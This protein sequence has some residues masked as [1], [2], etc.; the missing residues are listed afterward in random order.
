MR[1][2]LLSLTFLVILA[3]ISE[4]KP[5]ISNLTVDPTSL[6]LGESATISLNCIDDNENNTIIKTYL[7]ISGP[8]IFI[9][10]WDME[11]IQGNKYSLTIDNSYL[12]KT[13]DYEVNVY[14]EN[15]AGDTE[16]DKVTFRISNLINEINEISPDPAYL[17]DQLEIDVFVKKDDIKLNSGVNFTVEIGDYK[18]TFSQDPPP[19]YDG[20]R[21]WILKI[22]IPDSIGVYDLVVQSKYDRAQATVQDQIEIKQP[23]QFD[24]VN[25][26]KKYLKDSENITLTFQNS[27]KGELFDLSKNNLK[28]WID[29]TDC[30]IL[31]TSRTGSYSYV[32]IKVPN[33]SPG[34]YDL[35][36]RLTYE[37]LDTKSTNY[38]VKEIKEKVNYIVTVSGDIID[39][40]DNPVKTSI[41]FKNSR[42]NKKIYTDGEG[43]YSAEIPIGDYEIKLDFPGSTII[44]TGVDIG[45]FE[46]PIRYDEVSSGINIEGIGVVEIFVYEFALD[47]EEAYIEMEYDDSKIPDENRISLYRCE[48]WN[49][50]RRECNSEWNKISAN[51][52]D[53]RNYVKL[54]TT[55]LSTFLVGYK[56]EMLVDANIEKEQYYLNDIIK[57]L[58]IVEDEE[59]RAVSGAEI[60]G[61]IEGTNI[62]FKTESDDGGVFSKE[63]QGPNKEGIYNITLTADKSPYGKVNQTINLEVV[64]SK[65]LT[66]TVPSSIK[67]RK[68]ENKTSEFLINNIGQTDFQNLV[69]SIE[70][71]PDYYN[72]IDG[73]ISELKTGEKKI[74]PV[75]LQIPKGARIETYS[76]KA[77]VDYDNVSLEEKFLLNILEM[78]EN[79]TTGEVQGDDQK[80]PEFSLPSAKIVIP[81]FSIETILISI[82][83]VLSV[84][85]AAWFRRKKNI[86]DEERKD[87]KNLLLDI[88]REI[89]REHTDSK[90]KSN[91]RKEQI[92]YAS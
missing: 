64:R 3:S 76:G 80:E 35:R 34:E 52:D 53:I 31:E 1:K 26:D 60:K 17:G 44:L 72:I 71:I 68:G 33:L 45:D 49:F 40:D 87:V 20:G 29:N 55:T 32:K 23:L 38:F 67:V 82:F 11:V 8:D 56:K 78:E 5:V 24:L 10:D 79:Q 74:V 2:L 77:R 39:A 14:C 46:D 36:I 12:Y 90:K 50:G 58:G 57:I 28:I 61:R 83:G 25:I 63:F 54:N 69:L 37:D 6:W 84:G 21:G 81:S 62:E 4:A 86:P 85:S 51:A 22:D 75:I 9:S 66:L 42:V 89:E 41:D 88:K 48:S 13:G 91:K 70:G 43:H 30:E 27:Y 65:K 16:T 73:E 19:L 15:V 18:K 7:N 59:Q 47:F 92:N